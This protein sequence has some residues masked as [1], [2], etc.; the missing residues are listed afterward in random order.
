MTLDLMVMPVFVPFSLAAQ[1]QATWEGIGMY[2]V[3][4]SM[5]SFHPLARPSP[6]VSF[7]SAVPPSVS[8]HCAN[9]SFHVR[10][11]HGS[12]GRNF[13]IIV[14]QQRM[15]PGLASQ[16][17]YSQE[18]THLNFRVPFYSREVVLEVPS[19]CRR[20]RR[21]ACKKVFVFF[22]VILQM[23]CSPFRPSRGQS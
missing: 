22:R 18:A 7:L 2:G 12:Q 11:Q 14:G 15:T 4:T 19:G 20:C 17:G 5:P 1:L 21:G 10:V 16:Y 13:H 8:V 23:A 9:R 6:S 3:V